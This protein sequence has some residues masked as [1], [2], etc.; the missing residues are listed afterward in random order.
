MCMSGMLLALVSVASADVNM[1]YVMVGDPG[2]MDD[3]HGNG[4]GGVPYTYRIGKYEVTAG[5]YTEFLNAVAATDTYELY[6]T[7]LG[8]PSLQ[9][10]CHILRNGSPS[11]YTYTIEADWANRPLSYVTWGSAARFC[12]WLTNGQPTG[13]QNTNTTEDGSYFLNGA[14]T[15]GE[16]Q[17]VT[18]KA[19]AR[20]VIPTEDEWYKG[21]YYDPEKPGGAGYWLYPTCS[22]TAPSNVLTSPDPG[23][24]ANHYSDSFTI[25]P[26][27]Y[28]TEVGAFVNSQ[29]AYGTFDQGGNVWEWNE[30]IIP[31]ASQRG[32]R[33]GSFDV[34]ER[35]MRASSW[36]CNFPDQSY[37]GVQGFRVAEVPEPATLSL[38]AVGAMAL[39]R[40]RR[41]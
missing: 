22:D 19:D 33:G 9:F 18:R 38:L 6:S 7:F 34:G 11:N 1:Q 30:A 13:S 40:R 10:N 29:S 8:D 2:N 32:N 20:Y 36:G 16:L 12:N 15:V 35:G 25:G 5:Q 17:A 26:P 28:L 14:T 39:V 4:Y 27:Y 41:K 3:T 31:N 21:A 37:I 24:N 23:N